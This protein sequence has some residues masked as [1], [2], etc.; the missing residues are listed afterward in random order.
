MNRFWKI[1]TSLRITVTLLA[2]S[3][4]LIFFGTL[5]Q[6]DQ[7][8]WKAQTIWFRSYYV[9]MQHLQ[10][11]DWR[12]VVPFF[13]GGRLIG[14]ALFAN[15]TAAFLKRFSWKREKIGIHLVHSGVILLL[16]GQL[17][18]EI[19]S[20][21][22]TIRL[23]LGQ[24]LNYSEDQLKDEL[25]FSTDT[26]DGKETVVAIPG[27]MLKPGKEIK[28]DALP[29]TVNVKDYYVNSQ[30]RRRGPMVDSPAVATQGAGTQLVVE[31][32]QEVTDMDSRNLPYAYVELLKGT[33]S[34]GTWLVTP[35][36]G[37]LETPEQEVA[38]DGKNYRIDFRFKRYYKP[39]AVTLLKATHETYRG[40]DIP[41]DYRSRIRLADSVSNEAREVDIYMNHPLR[42]AGST[43]Y[44]YQVGAEDKN[45][46]RDDKAPK[47]S[48]LQVVHNP[49]WLTPYAGCYIV[50]MGMYM[51]FRQHLTR[52][53]GK[54]LSADERKGRWGA[55]TG[56]LLEV[57]I[58]AY[59]LFRFTL[60]LFGSY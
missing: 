43:F 48:T 38:V 15:L 27:S 5:A 58:L 16:L 40:T 45:P 51:Q 33:Q 30:L 55:W 39:F 44:Q 12:F 56:R 21:E 26:T 37:F 6:V 10:L 42:Y 60:Q 7:G 2:L 47:E 59:L 34:L 13:P 3:V 1:L 31:K 29:F 35:W 53:L 14:F 18:T 24:T 4:L 17:A 9:T 57:A 50:A 20:N 49:G 52:F 32:R 8:L 54:R 23:R 19:F 11:F 25:T 41:K 22:S 36:L 28:T 46:E